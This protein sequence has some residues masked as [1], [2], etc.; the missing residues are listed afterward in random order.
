MGAHHEGALAQRQ[1]LRAHDPRDARPARQPDHEDDDLQARAEDRRQHDDQRDRRQHQEEVGDPHQRRVDRTA[2][3]ARDQPDPR[4]DHD[5]DHGREQPDD[6]R[7]A[8]GHQELRPD[9]AT[10]LVGA[11]PVLARGRRQDV[12]RARADLR[13]IE[14]PDHRPDHDEQ[15]DHRE[16]DQP[17][18][19]HRVVPDLAPDPPRRGAP[20]GPPVHPL[21]ALHQVRHQASFT[22]GS[23]T[24]YSRS[25]RKFATITVNA[26]SRK[27]ASSTG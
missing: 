2:A 26:N 9:V 3:V 20:H 13:R 4:A 17:G 16:Q 22:R 10:E 11:E 24:R 19:A 15:D 14:R 21:G 25:A 18:S 8:P 7:D 1:H 27:H 5:R 23:S 6:D 12:G